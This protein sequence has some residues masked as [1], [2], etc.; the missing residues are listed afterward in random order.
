M[1]ALRLMPPFL[2]ALPDGLSA[3]PRLDEPASE[4]NAD[5]NTKSG[6]PGA[7][8]IS[9][10]RRGVFIGCGVSV[11][12]RT[13]AQ[14]SGCL[15]GVNLLVDPRPLEEARTQSSVRRSDRGPGCAS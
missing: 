11:Y 10:Q 5:W 7:Q 6:K 8:P 3:H 4:E 2:V 12:S 1:A 14:A 13:L 9:E 15:A